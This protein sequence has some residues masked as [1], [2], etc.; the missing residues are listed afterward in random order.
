M[1]FTKEEYLKTYEITYFSRIREEKHF[2]VLMEGRSTGG[3]H[4]AHGEEAV[5]AGIY[6]ELTEDDWFLPHHRA[7]PVCAL[8]Y[9]VKSFEAE[10]QAKKFGGQQG[11][12]GGSHYYMHSNKIGPR[13]AILGQCQAVGT[14]IAQ[15]YKLKKIPGCVVI[16]S[17][18]G[19]L[20]L[21]AVAEALNIIAAFKLP[22]AF[23]IQNNGYAISTTSKYSTGLDSLAERARGFGLPTASYDGTD[24]FLVKEVMREAMAR[25]R[26]C[27]PS[28][29]EFK[30]NRWKGHFVGDNEIYRDKS[31]VE[32]AMANSDPVKIAR[33]FILDNNIATEE[34]LLAIEKEQD[35]IVDEAF[36]YATSGDTFNREETRE[37]VMKINYV[38]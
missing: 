17:G 9:G 16:G 20:N 15:Y 25:A 34:E 10:I 32:E 35:R 3:V 1:S 13:I 30:T 11:M 7:K 38:L 24:P 21:G 26:K 27:E 8:R 22:V 18:D 33:N 14:G 19:D 4:L 37:H 31:E 28:V 2:Q 12:G 23:Y 6:S 29:V 36:E 5:S